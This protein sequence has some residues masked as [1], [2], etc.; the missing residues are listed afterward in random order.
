[1]QLANP[2]AYVIVS[3]A[4]SQ[5]FP[6]LS[7]T[8]A[9]IRDKREGAHANII[10]LDVGLTED[11]KAALALQN[12]ETVAPGWDYSLSGTLPD[13]FKSM[14]AR[15]HLPRWVPG[16][17]HYF[18][19]DADAWIQHWSSVELFLAGAR[20]HGFAIASE[21]DRAYTERAGGHPGERLDSIIELRFTLYEA[22]FGHATA[23]RLSGYPVLNCG[24]FAAS[25]QSPVWGLWDKHLLTALESGNGKYGGL[26]QAEQYA[27]NV[28][29]YSEGIAFAKLPAAHNW[30]SHRAWPVVGRE[31]SLVHPDFPHEPIGIVHR[32][33][34]TKN[35]GTR[36]KTID[37]AP[38]DRGLEYCTP[39]TS[40]TAAHAAS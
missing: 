10:I 2:R 30:M 17:D 31:G 3:A 29:L 8:I 36:L 39:A 25:A 26:F 6:L 7:Q 22:F 35:L 9:S 12:V 19:V 33:A 32:T 24:V 21:A 15:A 27:L 11:E 1:M 5:F 4:N 34:K 23:V 16:Y 37:G 20:R 38:T 13:W 40:A 14:T 18:W 28:A